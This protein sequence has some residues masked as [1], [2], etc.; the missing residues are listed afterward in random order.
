MQKVKKDLLAQCLKTTEKVALKT[1]RA[2]RATFTF[3]QKL[4]KKA[5]NS[6]FQQVFENLKI[7]VQ[8]RYQT[9]QF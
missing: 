1:L 9:G 4:I 7:S 6:Q 8:Q 3:R 2:K 5:K